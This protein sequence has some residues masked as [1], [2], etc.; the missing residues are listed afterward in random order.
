ME[1]LFK[2]KMKIQH[3][4]QLKKNHSSAAHGISDVFGVIF[5][6]KD[7]RVCLD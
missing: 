5:Q 1:T 7:K 3:I 2:K 4:K 6:V